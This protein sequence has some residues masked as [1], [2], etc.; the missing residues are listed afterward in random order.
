MRKFKAWFAVLFALSLIGACAFFPKITALFLDESLS[1]EAV[2][3]PIDPIRLEIRQELP[4]LGKL[5]VL[6]RA[7]L[8]FEISDSKT[9]MSKDQVMDAMHT[10]LAPY[11][12]TALISYFE[13]NIQIRP[14]IF[15]VQ[16]N[17]ELQ[18]VVWLVDITHDPYDDPKSFSNI[19]LAIDDETGAILAISY[20]CE[21][22]TNTPVGQ[23]ALTVFAEIYFS[24]LGIQNYGAFLMPD[25]E[26]AYWG[27]NGDAARYC[28]E[29]AQY[30]RFHVDLNV[31]DHGFYV[32]FSQE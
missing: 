22:P 27:D 14:D 23:D 19:G 29:D 6:S 17:P 10:G 28:F 8:N 26:S 18:T 21:T 4:I 15:Q 25:M 9:K 5:A 30:G 3:R 12:D 20:T 1:S 16:S 31:H 13:E 24:G 11:T 7:D 32:E 2:F